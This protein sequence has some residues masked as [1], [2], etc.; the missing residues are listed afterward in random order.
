M[1][2]LQPGIYLVNNIDACEISPV[3]TCL[4]AGIGYVHLVLDI[5]RL[6]LDRL[7]AERQELFAI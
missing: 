1:Q 7:S 4:S 2:Y 6:F 3:A 5:V